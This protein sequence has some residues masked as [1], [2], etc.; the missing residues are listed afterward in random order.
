MQFSTTRMEVSSK[1]I[2]RSC[3]DHSQK[4]LMKNSDASQKMHHVNN[5]TSKIQVEHKE[6]NIQH[7]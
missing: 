6:V 2:C 4:F 7:G 1:A 3:L 5:E